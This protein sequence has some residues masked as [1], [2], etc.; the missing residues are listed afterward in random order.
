MSYV[1]NVG[2]SMYIDKIAAFYTMHIIPGITPFWAQV[3]YV[4]I[5]YSGRYPSIQY[6][7]KIWC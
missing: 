1:Y 6:K 5:R 7:T 3:Y 4:E 2:L